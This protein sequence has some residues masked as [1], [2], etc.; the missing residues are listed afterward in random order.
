MSAQDKDTGGWLT[1]QNAVTGLV[2]VDTV[3]LIALAWWSTSKMTELEK[4]ND[5][6]DKK[7]EKLEKRVEALTK[8]I[9]KPDPKVK[10]TLDRHADRVNTIEEDIENIQAKLESL[11]EALDKETPTRSKKPKKQQKKTKVV[12]ESESSESSNNSE[13]EELSSDDFDAIYA[14]VESEA[15]STAKKSK[16]KHK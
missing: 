3:G 4:K 8:Q 7:V 13:L 9:A 6:L 15:K 11:I 12:K 16:K 10:M 2:L 14:Q 5:K 1:G